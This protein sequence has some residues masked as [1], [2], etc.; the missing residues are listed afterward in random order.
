MGVLTD[1]KFASHSSSLTSEVIQT[2]KPKFFKKEE[3]IARAKKMNLEVSGTPSELWLGV[4]LKTKEKV[5]GAIVVQSYNDPDIYHQKDMD[6]LIAISDQVALAIDRKLAEDA[7]NK[8]EEINKVLF[9]ISNASNTTSDL[10][11]LYK[12]IHNS[13]D[14]VIDLTNFIIGSYDKK[15]NTVS[16]EYFIDQFDD[17][18][19][20]S[21]ALKEGSIGG[22]VIRS[23]KALLLKEDDLKKR[24]RDTK[25]IGT[26]PKIWMGVPLK[27]ANNVIGYMATQS[28]NDPDLFNHRDLEVFSAVSEQVTLAI[29]RKRAQDAEIE[30]KAINNVLF[31]I[32]NA[33]NIA[34]KPPKPI[35]INSRSFRSRS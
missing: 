3:A 23:G 25:A 33:V 28:Y 6:L 16:F 30:N 21:V 12:S 22:D 10:F 20:L 15:D 26:W 35:Y 19:G 18:Q 31:S 32:S 14:K 27:T 29:D 24:L 8:S 1:I 9:K 13:L 34:E 11:E 2:G 4:P 17:F 5:I 7:Q